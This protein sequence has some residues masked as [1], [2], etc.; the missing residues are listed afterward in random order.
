VS[1][2]KRTP[3]SSAYCQSSHKSTY[4]FTCIRSVFDIGFF[5]DF[6]V[7]T[8]FTTQVPVF[9]ATN[10]P[11][12][13][14]QYLAEDEGTLA[15]TFAPSVTFRFA[16]FA[17][18]VKLAGLLAVRIFTFVIGEDNRANAVEG[19]VVTG[20]ATGIEGTVV[21]GVAMGVKGTVA[22]GDETGVEGIVVTGGGTGS[23]QAIFA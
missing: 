18:F 22:T 15:A 13:T 1:A 14:A 19:I 20:A 2:P 9:K 17:R 8:T 23:E 12:L 16:V 4:F 6:D 21:T 7:T 10:F 5:E 3:T 11:A